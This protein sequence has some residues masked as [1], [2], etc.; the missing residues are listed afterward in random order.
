[1]ASTKPHLEEKNTLSD[2]PIEPRCA[3]CGSNQI[4]VDATAQWDVEEQDWVLCGTCDHTV[5]EDCGSEAQ[6]DWKDV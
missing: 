4:S 3:E 2:K 1:M 6:P 5:C